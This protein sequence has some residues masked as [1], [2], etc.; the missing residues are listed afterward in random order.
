MDEILSM[1]ELNPTDELISKQENR[2]Q[3][4][5]SVTEVEQILK[6]GSEYL[7]G[8]RYDEADKLYTEAIEKKLDSASIY[9][10]LGMIKLLKK[11]VD[12][13][14]PFLEKAIKLDHRII[15]AYQ[16]LGSC[17]VVSLLV[18]CHCQLGLQPVLA[19]FQLWQLFLLDFSLLK[20]LARIKIREL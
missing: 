15:E 9:N 16:N 4:E 7:K 19:Q 6:K 11:E 8:G 2:L 5:L 17:Y 12:V 1:N 20:N 3:A 18:L 13:A 14:I 10:N